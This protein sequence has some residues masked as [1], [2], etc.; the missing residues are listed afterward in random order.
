MRRAPPVTY[1]VGRSLH[2]L[3]VF[4]LIW[5]IAAALTVAWLGY[6]V[7]TV[8]PWVSVAALLICAGAGLQFWRSSPSGDLRWD[9]SGWFLEGAGGHQQGTLVVAMDLQG[10]VVARWSAMP[11][12][13]VRWFVARDAWLWLARAKQPDRWAALRCA[14]YSPTPPEARLGGVGKARHQP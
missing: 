12:P 7:S 4:A 3:M 14:V 5:A 13:T 10:V 8:W 6:P 11:D 9:G 2:P 1:P